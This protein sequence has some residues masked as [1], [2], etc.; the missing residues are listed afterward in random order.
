MNTIRKRNTVFGERYKELGDARRDTHHGHKR[1][2]QQQIL[3]KVVS[4]PFVAVVKEIC[5][6]IRNDKC[7]TGVAIDTGLLS[8]WLLW[9]ELSF[10]LVVW[11]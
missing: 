11:P 8:C 3:P 7:C 10:E 5:R 2:L 1:Q 6:G 4:S 9:S